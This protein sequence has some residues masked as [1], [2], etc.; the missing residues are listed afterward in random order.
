M[1]S[2][3]IFFMM[4][5][6]RIMKM[7][8]F[9]ILFVLALLAPV[10]AHAQVT[11][12]YQT[13]NGVATAK[14]VSDTPD[15]NGLYTI[16]LETFA[17]GDQTLVVTATPV[18][19]ILVLD[20]SGSMDY[21]KGDV[22]KIADNNT[23]IN[24][25]TIAN[26]S[27]E[28]FYS[29][30][31]TGTRY[32]IYAEQSN[33]TYYLRYNKAANN[34]Q[35][36]NLASGSN[37]NNVSITTDHSGNTQLHVFRGKSRMT[38]LKEACDA[39]IDE[40][41]KNDHVDQ[42][43]NER[44]NRLGNQI[45]IVKFAG[46][47]LTSV[48]NS[49]YTSGGNTYNNTQTVIGFTPT[50][51]NVTTLKNAVNGFVSR[52]GTMSNYG[53]ERAN[54]LLQGIQS[55]RP[56]TSKVIVMFTDGE[57]G[58]SG[59][60]GDNG[61]STA[62]NCISQANIS[63]T[64]YG[65]TVYTVGVFTSSP[66]SNSNT[67]KYLDGVSS[68]WS[69]STA[70]WRNNTLTVSGTRS[71]SQTYYKDASGNVNLTAIF[72]EISSGIGGASATV[73]SSTQVRDVVSSSFT[74]PAGTSASNI[75]V[76]TMDIESDGSGWKNRQTPTGVTVN[77]GK[78]TYPG[79]LDD[80]GNAVQRDT[81]GVTGFDYSKLDSSGA[82]GTTAHPFDGNWVGKRY[83]PNSSQFVY[84]GKKLVIEFKVRADG[85]AT[86]GDGSA[87]NHPD[88]GVYVLGEN[89]QYTNVNAYEV[90]HTSLPLKL[91]IKKSGL[92]SGESAT[93]EI[94]RCRPKKR[95]PEGGTSPADSVIVYNAIGKPEPNGKWE[96]WSKVIV[97]NKSNVD[98]AMVTKTLV[99][100]DPSYVYKITE[101][102]WGWAYT[103]TGVGGTLTT[104]D[105]ELNPFH[106]TNEEKADAV[107]HAEAVMINHF[108]NP[109]G[110]V[111]N[112]STEHAKSSKVESFTTPGS[113]SGTGGGN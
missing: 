100:L 24:Y 23:T 51:N 63:K 4:L 29:S 22:T 80:E 103:M 96:D 55:S 94:E 60:S 64:T 86:G 105:V 17:T 32:R 107:K 25:N 75:T 41:E 3:L 16:T 83:P 109:G 91:I 84:A 57:P 59:F 85:N 11:T 82:N 70:T 46:N 78:K 87:T 97:T 65:A 13:E 50:Y 112:S 49:T 30:S 61:G 39:F 68:N 73:G 88:S 9:Y 72:T 38:A 106:F 95:M 34:G 18:D 104:S 54:A 53:M 99:S 74:L 33:G 1:T 8:R 21:P 6:S 62:V 27:E 77:V 45:A 58:S 52:G 28:Y 66:A 89:G 26:S 19:V 67:Y 7:N 81:V 35:G 93:F 42:N 92:R 47:Q 5:N 12:T 111:S 36:T 14:H 113:N 102:K 10:V 15:A 90:P 71:D 101:D 98:G 108:A 44:P 79:E 69:T 48:G 76:Y 2:Y 37:A 20:V 31:A 56:N 40:I 43:G 110:G